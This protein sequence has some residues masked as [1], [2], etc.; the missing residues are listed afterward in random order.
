MSIASKVA[1]DKTHQIF[2]AQDPAIH[3]AEMTQVSDELKSLVRNAAAEA[4]SLDTVERHIFDELFK[5]GRSAINLFLALQGNG[6]LGETV[7]TAAD[8]TLERSDEPADRELRTVFGQHLFQ[9]FVYAKGPHQKIELRPLDARMALPEGIDSYYFEELSQFFCVEQAF[10]RSREAIS[11]TLK[12]EVCEAQLQAIN[13]RMGEQARAY[14]EQL[15]VPPRA[16]EG[17]I[18]VQTGDGKGVPLVKSDAAR[19]PV[20]GDAPQRP[21]NRRMATLASVYSVDRYFRTADDVLAALFRDPDRPRKNDRPKPQFKELRACFAHKYE[22]SPGVE[23]EVSG[24]FEAFTWAA[25]RVRLRLKPGQDLVRLL[26]GQESLRKTSETCLEA[27]TTATDI[28]DIIHVAGYV[29]RAAKV[30]HKSQKHREAFSRDMLEKILNGQVT[31]VIHGLRVKAGQRHLKGK[32]LKEVTTVCGYFKNNAD[33]MRYDE[34]LQQ[35]YP[36]ATGVIEGA[37]KHLVKDRMERTGMR[38][39]LPNAQAMLNVRAVFQSSWWDA[40]QQHRMQTEQ[41]LIHANRALVNGYK[42]LC[43]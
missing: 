30:F 38:W 19:V 33:R 1:N 25:D 41:K 39:C 18:L 34:Y 9:S 2:L 3:D 28:L 14:M 4:E 35:G 22:D 32:P 27:G 5:I 29:K 40:F 17:E 6:D 43:V 12:Q 20:T 36:I 7:C 8:V 13:H 11:T 26:D 21:G 16:E 31:S 10:G 42:P 23:V 37:C 15:P 24:A